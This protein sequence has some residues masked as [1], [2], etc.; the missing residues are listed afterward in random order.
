M[1]ESLTYETIDPKK[2]TIIMVGLGIALFAACFDGT[3]TTT[4][5]PV[6]ASEFK[7]SDLLPWLT[8]AYLLLETVTIPLSG[9]L[10]DLYGRKKLLM[11][12]LILFGSASLL[13]GIAWDMWVVILGRALQG[14]GG[15]ILIPVATAAV[16]DLYAPEDRGKIQ[17]A[18]GALF[19]I[20]TGAGPL[21]GGFFA[22]ITIAGMSGW[23]FAFLINLV[24]VIVVFFMCKH[25]FPSAVVEGKPIIDYKGIAM[26]SSALVLVVLFFQ[27]LGKEFDVVSIASIAFLLVII[28]ILKL[29]SWWETKAKE[30]VIAPHLFSNPTVKTAAILLFLLGFAMVGDELFMGMYLQ[31]VTGH[32]A[33]VAGLYILIMV[34][35]MIIASTVCGATLN[36]V[37]IKK[38]TVAGTGLMMAGFFMFSLITTTFDP[39]VFSISEFLFGLGGGCLLAPLMTAVQNSCEHKDVGMTTSAVNLM[40]NIGATIGTSVFTLLVNATIYLEALDRGLSEEI[41]GLG[42]GIIDYLGHGIDDIIKAVFT[43][44]V[45][46]AF[47]F[48]ALL[49]LVAVI[50]ALRFKVVTIAQTKDIEEYTKSVMD[51][52]PKN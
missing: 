18:L 1:T 15:G 4:C 12:G 32:S 47:G 30:P 17:G 21:I 9:K 19:G 29:F 24:I 23:H 38:W 36:K 14:A 16:S 26:I 39:V 48:G 45:A 31:K 3:I 49:L 51:E 5:G 44:G 2:R 50:M 34:I 52:D 28:A 41:A 37:G 8:T 43:D 13:A 7:A 33:M 46:S 6:I 42:I 27:M 35:G 20:G 10:S 22:S 25:E 11:V 40:R